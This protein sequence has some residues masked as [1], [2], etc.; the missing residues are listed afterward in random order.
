MDR[1]LAAEQA[2]RYAE[3]LR[4]LYLG[5]RAQR[6]R[7]EDGLRRLEGSY[8]ATVRALA[9]AL[10]LRDD[11]TGGHAERVTELALRLTERVAPAL[12]ADPELEY[13]FFL[14]DVGKI[15]V[16]DAILLKPGALEAEERSTM[17]QH[18][19]Y[20]ARILAQVPHLGGLARAIVVAHHERWDGSGY[21]RGIA[22]KEIPLAARIFAI[23]DAFDAMTHDRP[24]RAALPGGAALD[25]IEARAGTQ[26]DP[27]LMEPF[28]GLIADL[29]RAA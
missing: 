29:E 18:P 25:E 15:G 17:E 8:A 24:Y 9:V 22:G 2:L 4:E 26:F 3:E 1:E 7:A 12:A 6:Q 19:L 16:P 13:G 28:L 23:V 21:P 10:E 20:G 27:T 11:L 14:H 5:E